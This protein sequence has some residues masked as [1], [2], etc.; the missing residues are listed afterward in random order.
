MK[1]IAFFAEDEQFQRLKTLSK[2]TRIKASEY[3]REG[4]DLVLIK[5]WGEVKKIQKE[6]GETER[7]KARAG[8]TKPRG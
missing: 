8:L 1:R 7:Q 2:A 4:I 3:I 6:R 5:H